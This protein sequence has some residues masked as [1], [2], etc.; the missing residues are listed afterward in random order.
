MVN[1]KQLLLPSLLTVFGLVMLFAQMLWEMVDFANVWSQRIYILLCM[2]TMSIGVGMVKTEMSAQISR[3]V[4][5]FALMNIAFIMF[6]GFGAINDAVN[7]T[8][9]TAGS[10][11]WM[12]YDVMS[13]PFTSKAIEFKIIVQT[14]IGTLP[15]IILVFSIVTVLIASDPDETQS[16]ILEFVMVLGVLIS[17]SFFGNL[18]GFA[19]M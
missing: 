13:T 14:L 12:S 1:W 8:T 2:G 7:G 9:L 5:S 16:A 15:A 11:I 6:G 17:F 10:G 4:L 19:W 3:S 18:F